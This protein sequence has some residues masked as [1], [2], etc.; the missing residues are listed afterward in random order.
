MIW[1]NLI[2]GTKLVEVKCF[3]RTSYLSRPVWITKFSCR[4][5]IELKKQLLVALFRE[6]PK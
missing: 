3:C 4:C 2:V 5:M 1:E 6:T